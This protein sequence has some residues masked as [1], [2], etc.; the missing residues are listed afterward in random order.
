MSGSLLI[1]RD[2]VLLEHV[3]LGLERPPRDTLKLHLA[4]R[5]RKFPPLGYG[6]LLNAQGLGERLLSSEVGD[7]VCF[8]H[9][10]ENIGMPISLSIGM[11]IALC[12]TILA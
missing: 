9:E 3:G 1:Q 6:R 11:P 10:A 8:L 5:R 2:S 7:R 12:G 4:Q